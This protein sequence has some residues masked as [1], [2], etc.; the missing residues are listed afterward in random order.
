MIEE[1]R[2][3]DLLVGEY[4][5]LVYPSVFD[6]LIMNNKPTKQEYY[7]TDDGN[8]WEISHFENEKSE[9]LGKR[10]SVLEYLSKKINLAEALGAL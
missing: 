2:R 9:E 4:E 8:V 5:R 10:M 3:E 7:R 6:Y 1:V